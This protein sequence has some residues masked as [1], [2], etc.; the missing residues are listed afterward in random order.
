MS[1]DPVHAVR[2]ERVGGANGE[3]ERKVR[4]E[5]VEAVGAEEGACECEE[6]AGEKGGRERGECGGGVQWVWV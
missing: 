5:G 1:Y 6:G 4:A 3:F 2:D